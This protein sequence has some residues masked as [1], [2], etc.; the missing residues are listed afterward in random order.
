[1]V[2]LYFDSSVSNYATCSQAVPC[3]DIVGT[4]YDTAGV[5]CGSTINYKRGQTWEGTAALLTAGASSAT[6]CASNPIYV[7]SYGTGTN[8]ILFGA[9]V[10]SSGWSLSTLRSSATASASADTISFTSHGFGQGDEV[11]FEADSMP[12][13]L[14]AGVQYFV[15]NSGSN[16]C[17]AMASSSLFK[18]SATR[19]GAAINLTSNGTNV[20]FYTPT[21]VQSTAQSQSLLTTVAWLDSGVHKAA[22]YWGGQASS[23]QPNTFKRSGTTLYLRLPSDA[24]PSTKSPRIG[25]Y[26]HGD[27]GLLRTTT[28]ETK[29]IGIRFRDITV[30]G[31]NGDGSGFT[32]SGSNAE[33]L[34]LQV[35]GNG[36]DGHRFYAELAG[37]GENCTSCWSYRL[38]ASYN[39]AGSNGGGG[40]GQGITNYGGAFNGYT[41]TRTWE[42]FMAN[43]DNID[44]GANSNAIQMTLLRYKSWNGGRHRTTPSFDASTYNDGGHDFWSY[45]GQ[46]W[47]SGQGDGLASGARGGVTLGSEHPSTKP[48]YNNW[49]WNHAIYDNHW[50]GIHTDNTTS[51]TANITGI[52]WRYLTVLAAG[53]SAT[54]FDYAMRFDDL[55][56]TDDSIAVNHSIFICDNGNVC[57][58]MPTANKFTG[59]RNVYY[60]RGGSTTLFSGAATTLASWQTATS[61]E[62][63]SINAGSLPIVTDA[64]AKGD[65][66]DVKLPVGSSAIDIGGAGAVTYPS[67]LPQEIKDDIGIYGV[68]GITLAAGTEDDV[69][70]SPDAGFHLD[71]AR[72]TSTSVTA[73]SYVKSANTTLT[74]SFTVP[75]YVGEIVYTDYFKI[76]LPSGFTLN[77]GGTSAATSATMSG[78]FSA[79]TV[80]SQTI[81]CERAGDGNS[82]FYG[83]YDISI[84]NVG[85]PSSAGLSGTFD[86]EQY[87]TDDEK[88]MEGLDMEGITITEPVVSSTQTGKWEFT[89]TALFN[90][91][92]EF[93][94]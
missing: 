8:A 3:T 35:I 60:R 59:N 48:V 25:N 91:T 30:V 79:C 16:A 33:D 92:W 76:T 18:V 11:Y 89:G 93:R 56:T 46:V 80:A 77:S 42:N 38:E 13:G 90:G 70:V 23:L 67:W 12:G 73:A 68:R 87:D 47:G 15:R 39:A 43:W 51:S 5:D 7:Q 58:P 72:Y 45:G 44:F 17:D 36:G 21:Y 88:F 63:N 9:S 83:D 82:E 50:I 4:T 6:S 78:T 94:P 86:V 2:N 69:S 27:R 26:D 71:Y 55:S 85:L 74:F 53:S 34:G 41:H 20:K 66:P 75:R 62:A 52:D 31:G 61:E 28:D 22:G 84:S 40:T 49:V 64:A 14:T 81:T 10:T 65:T 29:A 32:A 54:N 37:S 57:A 1:M 19:C 24:D